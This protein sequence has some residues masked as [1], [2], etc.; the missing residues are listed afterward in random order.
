MKCFVL[1]FCILFPFAIVCSASEPNA[2]HNKLLRNTTIQGFACARGDAWFYPDGS[3]NQCT[4]SHASTLSDIR[5]PRGAVV[6]LWASGATHYLMLPH[7]SVL[8]GYRVRGGSHLG[9]SRGA[10]TTFYPTGE[11]RSIYLV[12]SQTVQGVPCHGGGWNTF[13]D[14]GGTENNV[15][16]YHDG[17]LRSCRLSR[18]YAGFRSGER[19][20]I[21]HLTPASASVFN[22]SGAAAQ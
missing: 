6:E 8:A 9:L 21:P 7:K 13:T 19:I 10:T 2:V 11:L 3:L 1:L 4:L 18:D 15:E 22:I 17:K 12:A 5:V 14:P 20:V 16:F